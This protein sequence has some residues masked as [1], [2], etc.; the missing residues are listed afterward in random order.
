[1][2][3]ARKNRKTGRFEKTTK[4]QSA[5]RSSATNERTPFASGGKGVPEGWSINE[6]FLNEKAPQEKL[7]K[8]IKIDNTVKG[9]A[10]LDNVKALAALGKKIKADGAMPIIGSRLDAVITAEDKKSKKKS[11]KGDAKKKDNKSE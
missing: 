5:T 1:M 2:A 9:N 6:E 3:K 7:P 10:Y 4:A 8:V 11:P